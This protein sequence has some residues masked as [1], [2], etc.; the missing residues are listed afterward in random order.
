MYWQ[1]VS[2]RLKSWCWDIIGENY[3]IYNS[4]HG[5]YGIL[6]LMIVM[7]SLSIKGSWEEG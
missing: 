4:D 2:G 5:I 1:N 7:G 6:K 3:L